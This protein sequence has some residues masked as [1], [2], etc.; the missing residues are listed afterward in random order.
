MCIGGAAPI[1]SVVEIMGHPDKPGDDERG[2][3][4]R[5]KESRLSAASSQFR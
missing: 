2:W 5:Q 3:A 1:A 4:R